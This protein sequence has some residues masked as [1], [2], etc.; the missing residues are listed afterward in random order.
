MVKEVRHTERAY[1]FK[2]MNSIFLMCLYYNRDSVSSVENKKTTNSPQAVVRSKPPNLHGDALKSSQHYI[3]I[4][5]IN[6]AHG[7]GCKKYEYSA[8]KLSGVK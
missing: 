5:G 7:V 1:N 4:A 2:M 3:Q 8:L 6:F